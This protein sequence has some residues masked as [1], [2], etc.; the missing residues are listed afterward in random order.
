MAF[1]ESKRAEEGKIIFNNLHGFYEGKWNG[2]VG[3]V[4][5][6]GFNFDKYLP[7]EPRVICMQRDPKNSLKSW[8]D[9][10]D[11]RRERFPELVQKRL[12]FRE[13]FEANFYERINKRNTKRIETINK[14]KHITVNYEEFASNPEN[15][16]KDFEC[17]FPELSFDKLKEG[18]D[19]KLY[20]R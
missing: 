12:P 4:K 15:Y 18:I 11:R 7:P 13:K 17:L 2:K 8:K 1:D 9:V 20:N 6:L 10:M 19:L 14:Y 5:D 16:R 3:A